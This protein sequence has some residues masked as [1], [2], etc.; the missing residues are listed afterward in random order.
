[1]RNGQRNHNV[2]AS[3]NR[4]A[5]HSGNTYHLALRPT[6]ELVDQ[7]G[8][9]HQFMDWSK[10]ILTDSGGF[11]LFSLA[12][13]TKITE[14]GA[15]FQ[16]H[17]D[18]A[19]MELSPERSVQIQELL[20]SDIAMVLDHLIELPASIAD[21]ED[22]LDRTTRWAK[23]SRD[24]HQK[25]DQFNSASSKGGWTPA[26]VN[27]RPNNWSTWIS[28][29]TPLVD[30][31]SAKHPKKCTRRSRSQNRIFQPKT[32]VLDGSGQARGSA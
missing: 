9:L 25:K 13:L 3:R 19:K 17:I 16:S 8:G 30:L 12:K 4:F 15:T 1:M 32:E 22:A 5:N 10:P 20:G 27:G 7:M 31:A 2:S 21:V 24:A 29:V 26:C 14:Q 6:A 11:Q 18:G 28:L 23:R